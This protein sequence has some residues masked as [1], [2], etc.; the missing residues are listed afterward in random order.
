[1][2]EILKEI[3]KVKNFSNYKEYKLLEYIQID[4]KIIDIFYKLNKRDCIKIYYNNRTKQFNNIGVIDI[5]G[6]RY[7]DFDDDIYTLTNKGI[8]SQ[9]LFKKIDLR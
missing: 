3:E 7:Y 8:D 5:D 1:M 4:D 9:I 2:D 6:L